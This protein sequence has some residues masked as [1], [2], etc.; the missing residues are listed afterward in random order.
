MQ[1]MSVGLTILLTLQSFSSLQADTQEKVAV[2][3]ITGIV[4]HPMVK[5]FPAVVYIDEMPGK[6]FKPE[7]KHLEMDQ[8]GKE[9]IPHILPILVGST[10]DF[11]NSD[12]FEHNVN[13]PDC[14]KYDLGKANKGEKKSNTFKDAC[15]YTQLCNL[16][17]EMLAYIVVVKTP[18]FAMTDSDGKFKIENVPVGNWKLKVWHERFKPALLDKTYDVQVEEAK[19]VSMELAP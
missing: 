10:V 18:Y 1:M 13:S 2:G 17:P 4:K 6:E 15:V 9:F 11:F 19:E 12:D 14:E 8:K 16:H 5:K 7:E 3:T